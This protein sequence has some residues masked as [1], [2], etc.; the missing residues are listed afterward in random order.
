MN[1]LMVTVTDTSR[2][3]PIEIAL[4]IDEDGMT[5]AKM[6][7]EFL[8]LNTAVYARWFRNNILENEFAEEGTD[9]FPFNTNVECGGQASKDA[10]LTARFAKKLS[11]TQKNEKGEQ[12]REYFTRVEDAA[13]EMVLRVNEMSPELQ[14]IFTHDKQIQAVTKRVDHLEDNLTINHS[15]A[16]ELSN[17]ARDKTLAIIGGKGSRAYTYQYPSKGPN[18]KPQ[19]L[20]KKLSRRLW[21]DYWDYFNITSR[22]NTPIIRLEEAKDYIKNWEPPINLRLDI[23]KVNSDDFDGFLG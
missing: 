7:Y 8:E 5:T 14:A 20:F 17:L 18:D 15:Q 13:K 12:A 3:T 22:D 9:Y 11:M 23:E 6:L 21:C 2:L 19:Y 16:K 4:G 10:R 1:D